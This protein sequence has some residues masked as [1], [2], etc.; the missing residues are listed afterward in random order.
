MATH[1]EIL[2]YSAIVAAPAFVEGIS[3]N[4]FAAIWGAILATAIKLGPR[5]DQTIG[6][7]RLSVGVV[8]VTKIVT[9]LLSGAAAAIYGAPLLCA[10]WDAT[11][12]TVAFVHFTL[13][14]VGSAIVNLVAAYDR[15]IATQ[16]WQWLGNWR[17]P[18]PPAKA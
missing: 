4:T 5:N 11:P 13:G 14:L 15:T 6:A 9:T 2:G 3:P 8:L 1:T 7:F 12:A 17:P 18:T 16:V 10:R